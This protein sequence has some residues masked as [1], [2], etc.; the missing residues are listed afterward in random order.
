MV[1]KDTKFKN[2]S[3][4]HTEFEL[5]KNKAIEAISIFYISKN[6]FNNPKQ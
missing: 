3:N 6:N 4:G 2:F 5:P 1:T